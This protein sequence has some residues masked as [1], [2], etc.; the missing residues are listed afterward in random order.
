MPKSCITCL[1]KTVLIQTTPDISKRA[2]SKT[3]KYRSIKQLIDPAGM[4][5]LPFVVHNAVVVQKVNDSS[6][7][8]SRLGNKVSEQG[9]KENDTEDDD[10]D[11]NHNL[12]LQTCKH[13]ETSVRCK[14]CCAMYPVH[15]HCICLIS[16][17]VSARQMQPLVVL[18]S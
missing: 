16:Q 17:L 1:L 18:L 11:E 15:S 5:S 14:N 13:N 7:V 6:V 8:V 2:P 10:T 3:R 4:I 9:S 12:L